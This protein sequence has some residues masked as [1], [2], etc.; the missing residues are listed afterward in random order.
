MTTNSLAVRGSLAD[1]AEHK[2]TRIANVFMDAD[3]IIIIDVS[4]S[5]SSRD[6]R[7]GEM[8]RYDAACKELTKLQANYQGR[9]AVFGFSDDV[10][11]FPGGIP[12]QNLGTGTDLTKALEYLYDL[13]GTGVTFD[14]ISDGEPDDER[15][16]L[17]QAR[18]YSTKINTI[19]IGPTNGY[20]NAAIAFM[21]KIATLSGGQSS[22]NDASGIGNVVI[23]LLKGA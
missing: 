8:T 20:Y 9:F 12:Q 4:G 16:A 21:D 11:I 1:L 18:R 7:G 14:L 23:G 6:V 3:H 22:V 19:Y 15:S 10:A 17:D 13:D 2:S 5:M